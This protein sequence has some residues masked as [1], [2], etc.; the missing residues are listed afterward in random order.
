[1]LSVSVNDNLLASE[2]VKEIQNFLKN[3]LVLAHT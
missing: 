1:M 3:S 2:E